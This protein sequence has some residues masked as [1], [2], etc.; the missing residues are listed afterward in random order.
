MSKSRRLGVTKWISTGNESDVTV[1]ECLEYMIDSD[2]VDVVGCYM[3]GIK[4]PEILIRA[5]KKARAAG[6]AVTIMKVGV[7]E[8]GSEALTCLYHRANVRYLV[9]V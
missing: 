7:S 5:L 9:C 6:K 3:E 8:V 2:S 4:N 1:A